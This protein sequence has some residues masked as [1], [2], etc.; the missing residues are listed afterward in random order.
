MSRCE[1]TGEG[2]EE[3]EWA[4]GGTSVFLWNTFLVIFMFSSA[5]VYPPPG[6]TLTEE[7]KRAMVKKMLRQNQG[8]ITGISSKYDYETGDWKKK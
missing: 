8:A 2:F 4:S 1:C 5:S 7:W 6:K 3:W